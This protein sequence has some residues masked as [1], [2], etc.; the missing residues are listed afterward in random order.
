MSSAPDRRTRPCPPADRG[1]SP[2]AATG[3]SSPPPAVSRPTTARRRA[4]VVAAAARHVHAAS[5]FLMPRAGGRRWPGPVR[6]A[7]ATGAT[8]SLDTERRPR[9]AVGTGRSWTRYFEFTDFLLPNAAEASRRSPVSRLGRSRRGLLARRGPLVV[10]K[11]GVDGA[12]AHDGTN[13]HDSAG[14]LRRPRRR[15]RRGRQLRRRL[16][17]RR[18]LNGLPAPTEPWRRRRLRRPVHPRR[19]AAPGPAHPG[20]GS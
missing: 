6:T 19:T 12:L 1:R 8:T 4:R 18:T 16:R 7:R 5:F 3:R 15:G 9:R 14:A 20:L 11:N 2:R 13:C 10:V 17:R